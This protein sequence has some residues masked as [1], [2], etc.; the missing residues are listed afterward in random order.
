MQAYLWLNKE[1]GNINE[2][3]ETN[4]L[5]IQNKKKSQSMENKN[6]YIKQKQTLRPF[7]RMSQILRRDYHRLESN[8]CYFEI[9]K[10]TSQD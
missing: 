1:H 2:K 3:M 7:V 10:N 5:E 6:E 8:F 4:I 9:K